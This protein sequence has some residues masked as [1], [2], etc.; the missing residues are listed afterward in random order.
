MTNFN[1]QI[2]LLVNHHIVA[3]IAVISKAK[4]TGFWACQVTA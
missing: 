4:E 2:P 3:D 1:Y